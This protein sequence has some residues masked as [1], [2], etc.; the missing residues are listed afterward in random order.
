MA[1][2]NDCCEYTQGSNNSR[3]EKYL[4]LMTFLFNLLNNQFIKGVR[5]HLF[6][7]FVK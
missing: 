2:K 7:S 6:F 1:A 4:V 5:Y 3:M